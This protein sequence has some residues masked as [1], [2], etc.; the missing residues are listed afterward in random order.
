MSTSSDRSFATTTQRK[1]KLFAHVCRRP[2]NLPERGFKRTQNKD[3][4][5]HIAEKERSSTSHYNLVHKPVPTPQA[6]K[7]PGAKAAA[8][9]EWEAIEELAIMGKTQVSEANKRL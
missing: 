8:D 4:G 7:S 5:D 3:L 9:K 1:T 2:T 6:M